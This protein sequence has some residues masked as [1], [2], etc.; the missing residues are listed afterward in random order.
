MRWEDRVYGE[1]EVTDR[2]ILGIIET[3]TFRR[4]KGVRQAGPSAIA[5]PFKNVTRYEHSLGVHVLLTRLGVGRQEQVAGLLH[6]IS[7]TAFSHAVD[8]L[9]TSDDQD[10]HESLKPEMLDRP[11]VVAALAPLG[12]TP[13][14]FYD[15]SRYPVLERPLPWLCADRLDYFLRDGLACRALTPGQVA[16]F[17]EHVRV[18]DATIVLADAAVAREVQACFAEMNRDWWA[19]PTEAYIYNEFADALREG[20]RLG[21][22]TD[23]DLLSEDQKVLAKLDAAGSPR[24]AAKLAAIRHF[25]PARVEGYTPRV[26]PKERWLD[27]PVATGDGYRRLSEMSR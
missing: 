10:H 16:R 23:E 14:D 26:I 2:A 13:R 19:S 20:F 24:I 21:V 3:P 17:L 5:F 7:H 9:V 6:D 22:I 11:D 18:V 27:P 8:F 25:D 12:F 15:D 1:V 4:L